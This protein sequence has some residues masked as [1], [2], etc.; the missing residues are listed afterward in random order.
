MTQSDD[1]GGATGG[2]PVVVD[3]SAVA[4][5]GELVDQLAALWR[6]ELELAKGEMAEKGRAAG[7]GAGMFGAAGVA[8]LLAIGC[9]TAAIIAA[10]Q[11]VM[12]V[13]LAS[14]IVAVAYLV[15]AG[16]AVLVGRRQLRRAAPLLPV[17]TIASVK[18]DVRWLKTHANIRGS[19]RTQPHRLAA[20]LDAL[21]GKTQVLVAK[22][23]VVRRVRDSVSQ[24]LAAVK[25]WMPYVIVAF[26]VVLLTGRQVRRR[27]SSRRRLRYDRSP[28]PVTLDLKLPSPTAAQA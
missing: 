27:R 6:D 20:T 26:V 25:R 21:V 17:E 24:V 13:W 22:T 18:E 7:I 11:L 12:P 8:V 16:A 1:P 14:L 3:R 28:A 10:L 15:G 2:S 19:I 9:L 23:N 5:A 4:L